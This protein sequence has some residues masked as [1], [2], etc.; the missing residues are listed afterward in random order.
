MSDEQQKSGSSLGPALLPQLNAACHGHLK[1]IRWFRTDWQRGGAATAYGV[2]GGDH[3]TPERD[4]V[5]KFPIGPREYRVLIGLGETDAPTPRIAFHGTQ[6]GSFDMAWV[7]MERMAGEPLKSDP[8]KASF[9]L[10]AEAVAS[11]YKHAERCWPLQE[12]ETSADWEGLIA[13]ARA[14]AKLN[15][16]PDAQRWSNT[17]HRVQRM[18]ER[19]LIKWH[20]RPVNAWCHGDLHL[21]NVML[22]EPDS[23]WCPSS[24]PRD[25]PTAILFDFANVR[26]GHWI[27]DA[28]YL[29]RQYWANRDIMKKVKPVSLIARARREAGLP[30]EDHTQLASIRRILLASCVPAFLEREGHPTY[31]AAALDTLEKQL[32][33]VNL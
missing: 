33:L 4:V 31:L 23:P 8:S 24:E 25:T 18:L 29:E 5:I 7:V 10:C 19:L 1:D 6:L 21:A 3:E 28:I 16:I 15:V 20:T 14:S 11:F 2:L 12:H 30:T 32:D 22:R 13:K 27:E 17:I 26:S 9:Q